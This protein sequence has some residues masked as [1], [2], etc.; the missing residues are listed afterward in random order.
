VQCS[1]FVIV[2]PLMRW[3]GMGPPWWHGGARNQPYVPSRT[4]LDILNERF[5]RGEIDQAKYEEKRRVISQ[6]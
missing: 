4:A 3:F 6:S 5:A 1:A 2:V